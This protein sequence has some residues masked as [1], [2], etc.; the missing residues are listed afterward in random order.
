MKHVISILYLL[1]VLILVSA[2]NS[3]GQEDPLYAQYLNNPL[4]INPAY[5]G[6][7]N[8]LSMAASY[9][10]QWSGF[11]GSPNTLNFNSHMAVGDNRMGLGL[12]V[13]QDRI[14]NSTNSECYATY[15]FRIYL[16]EGKSLSLGLQG[17]VMNYQSRNSELNTYDPTDPAF[18]SNL[19]TTKP[20]FGTGLIYRSDRLFVGLSVPRMLTHATDNAEDQ[21]INLYSQHLY[22]N[23][24]YTL[25]LSE[26]V[27]MKPSILFKGVQ[28]SPVSV[29]YNLL[30]NLNER[31][32]TGIFTRNLNTYGGII[33]MKL[34][35]ALGFGYALEIPTNRSVGAQYTTHE[36]CL[37]LNVATLASHDLTVNSF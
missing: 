16:S 32:T 11:E 27:R 29:D 35:E 7:R 5:T 9:R 24:A 3:F 4:L 19:N 8:N 13:L 6:I 28:G 14:G 25:F 31:Y 2:I 10:H 23:V 21:T 30:L 37:T 1:L 12:I 15:A 22:A 20:N 26:H 36:L 18:N 17:G 34:G 33:Q